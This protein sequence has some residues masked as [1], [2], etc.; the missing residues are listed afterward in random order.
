MPLTKSAKKKLRQDEKREIK[1]LSIKNLLKDIVK[2]ARKNPSPES[3]RIATK[4]TD[5]SVKLR[6]IHKNKAARLKSSLSKLTTIKDL[7]RKKFNKKT[8]Q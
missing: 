6:L 7:S 2:K 5:K 4:I 3:I 8:I 1:R